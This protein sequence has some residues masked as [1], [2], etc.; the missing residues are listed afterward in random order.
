[1]PKHTTVSIS[2]RLNSRANLLIL[3]FFFGTLMVPQ[4]LTRVLGH[5][6]TD[7]TFQDAILPVR[8]SMDGSMAFAH[9][10]G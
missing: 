7:L 9:F 2:F 1:M 4:I 10:R 5:K 3:V 8:T 6:G